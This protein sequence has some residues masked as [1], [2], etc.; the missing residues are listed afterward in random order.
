MKFVIPS[1]LFGL[2]SASVIDWNAMNFENKVSIDGFTAIHQVNKCIVLAAKRQS[3][4]ERRLYRADFCADE[5]FTPIGGISGYTGHH[6]YY[7]GSNG[8]TVV[9]STGDRGTPCIIRS[10]DAGLSWSVVY[11]STDA[12]RDAS[13]NAFD[14]GSIFSP[15]YLGENQWI[16]C[17]RDALEGRNIIESLDNGLTWHHKEISSMNAGCRKMI[18]QENGDIFYAGAFSNDED[19]KEDRGLF[20]SKD[21]GRN[22]HPYLKGSPVFSGMIKTPTNA[23]V[24]GTYGL[25]LLES[26]KKSC[27]AELLRSVDDGLTFERVAI[28]TAVSHVVYFR[29]ITRLSPTSNTLVAFMSTSEFSQT[30]QDMKTYISKNDGLDWELQPDAVVNGLKL[31]AIYE[32]IHFKHPKNDKTLMLAAAQPFNFILSADV[33]AY[34]NQQENSINSINFETSSIFLSNDAAADTYVEREVG[35]VQRI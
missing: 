2:F 14:A 11:S 29:H 16:A 24:V 19:R 25:C 12:S 13:L 5:V 10:T 15:L 26:N 21:K 35:Q 7:F 34:G 8:D 17:L 27:S 9:A 4:E 3:T 32:T 18:L 22:W 33:T 31:N 28:G 30:D 20:I 1:V 23:I 6:T